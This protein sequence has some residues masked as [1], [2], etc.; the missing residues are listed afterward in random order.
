MPPGGDHHGWLS[1]NFVARSSGASSSGSRCEPG[2]GERSHRA[3]E[4]TVRILREVGPN[5]WRGYGGK[6]VGRAL[7]G[8]RQTTRNARGGRPSSFLLRAP[9]EARRYVRDRSALAA[10]GGYDRIGALDRMDALERS[11]EPLPELRRL[12]VV[13]R[14]RRARGLLALSGDRG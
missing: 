10:A 14:L 5:K 2:F 3:H 1:R 11:L 12:R 8:R 9:E 7:P 4:P 6:R 13:L